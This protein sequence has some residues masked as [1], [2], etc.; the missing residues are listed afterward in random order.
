MSKRINTPSTIHNSPNPSEIPIL[1]FSTPKTNMESRHK[2]LERSPKKKRCRR[3]RMRFGN[4]SGTPNFHFRTFLC[5]SE[6]LTFLPNNAKLLR[7]FGVS[8]VYRRNQ[9]KVEM[10]IASQFRRGTV[11]SIEFTEIIH[12]DE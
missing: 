2:Q 6:K 12:S 10:S 9:R 1:R 11:P 7:F 5:R 3:K 8:L 4:S